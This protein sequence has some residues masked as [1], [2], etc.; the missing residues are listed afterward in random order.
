MVSPVE[1]LHFITEKCTKHLNI[2]SNL[3]KR[4]V[5]EENIKLLDIIFNSLK[6]YDNAFILQLLLHFK[7]KIAISTSD[8]NQLI[9]NEKFKIS[10]NT[11]YSRNIDKYLINECNKK[12]I[13]IYILKYLIKNGIDIN[14]EDCLG[15]TPL[16]HA[17]YRGN[18]AIV[19][20]LIEL[21]ADINKENWYGRTP[22]FDACYSGNEARVKYLIEHGADINKEKKRDGETPLFDACYRGNEAIVKYLIE[23]GADINKE[24]KEGETPLFNACYRGN[25]AIVKYLIELGAD[26]NMH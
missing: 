5:K 14:K 3:I 17:C 22:L 9:S 8:L 6:F 12:I 7:N 11:K 10:L 2:S 19:K 25:E 21:G 26:I 18:E 15:E 24:N 1:R 16:F 13:N 20:Y 23:L 4:L